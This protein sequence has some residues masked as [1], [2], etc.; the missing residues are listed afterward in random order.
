[1][2]YFNRPE[3]AVAGD[4][5]VLTKPLGTQIAV[6]AHQWIEQVR[7]KDFVRNLKVRPVLKLPLKLSD[8]EHSEFLQVVY[9]SHDIHVTFIPAPLRGQLW[10]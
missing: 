3:N 5:L 7:T 10:K 2:A 1:M 4:V 8:S 9:N 6:N